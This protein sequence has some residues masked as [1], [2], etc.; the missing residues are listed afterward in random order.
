MPFTSLLNDVTVT[1]L[2][3]VNSPYPPQGNLQR[4]QPQ[5]PGKF[6]C[7]RTSQGLPFFWKGLGIEYFLHFNVEPT[8][9]H[10]YRIHI[11]PNQNGWKPCALNLKSFTQQLKSLVFLDV[12]PS[13]HCQTAP[14]RFSNEPGSAAKSLVRHRHGVGDDLVFQRRGSCFEKRP[15]RR[16]QQ[17]ILNGQGLSQKT[18][19]CS[20]YNIYNRPQCIYEIHATLAYSHPQL[21]IN[22]KPNHTNFRS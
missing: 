15:I 14:L 3:V 1:W 11:Y 12:S 19:R 6:G 18:S 7:E 8:Q 22:D 10:M 2:W 5:I 17:N 20:I 13:L 4:H 9:S 21:W 16:Y